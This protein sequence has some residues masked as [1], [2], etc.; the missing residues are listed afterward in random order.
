MIS[1]A[2]KEHLLLFLK[3]DIGYED[4]T[5]EGIVSEGTEAE[6]VVRA[7]QPCVVAGLPFF[8]ELFKIYDP[9]VQIIFR[10]PEGT[11]IEAYQEICTVKGKAKTLLTVE[12][13]ALNLLQRLCGIATLT[14]KMARLIED[15][16]ARLVDTRKTTPGLRFFE[17]Y[18]T[19]IGGAVNHRMGLYDAVLVKDNH[20][21]IAGSVKEALRQVKKAVPFTAKIEVEVSSLKELEEA[22]SEG[23]DIILLDNMDVETIRKAVKLT[24]KIALLEASGGVTPESIREIAETGVDFISSG[25]I[26][27]HATWIDI[28]MKIERIEQIG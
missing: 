26:T 24:G 3:E 9:A 25:F 13:S 28:N 6:A 4:L 2:L 14:R 19:K 16:E 12:R 21:K 7:K 1:P 27:H 5:T 22:L 15:T 23:A 20:I 10:V 11:E 17:K 8:R 18:A